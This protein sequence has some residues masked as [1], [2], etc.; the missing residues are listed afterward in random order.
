MPIIHHL[1][2]YMIITFVKNLSWLNIYAIAKDLNPKLNRICV[3]KNYIYLF[4]FILYNNSYCIY[5]LLLFTFYY[6]IALRN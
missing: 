3:K 2:Q 4:Y 1:Y 5:F 6:L